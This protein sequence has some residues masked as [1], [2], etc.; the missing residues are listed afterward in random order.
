[1]SDLDVR[2]GEAWQ[3]HRKGD[4]NAALSIYKEVLSSDPNHVDAHYG[5]GLVQRSVGNTS[6]A[7][8]SFQRALALCH[9]QLEQMGIKRRE[10]KSIIHK[11]D[12]ST[13][14]DDRYN[15]LIRMI[16]QR[17]HELGIKQS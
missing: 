17:L 10:D 3:M 6:D 12:L 8:V 16:E 13:D 9:E 14:E 2:V 11:N 4:N 5:L 7:I 1:M 15:M